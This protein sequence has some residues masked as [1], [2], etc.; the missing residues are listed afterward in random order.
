VSCPDEK[1]PLPRPKGIPD[2][3]PSIGRHVREPVD[4]PSWP[5]GKDH[6]GGRMISP[7]LETVWAVA[8][9]AWILYSRLTF[10]CP[11]FKDPDAARLAFG[12][13]QRLQGVLYSEGAY[14]L[15][16][17]Q[18][19]TYLIFELPARIFRVDIAGLEHF[20]ALA[21]AVLMIGILVLN[22]HLAFMIWGRRVALVSTTVLSISPM[23]WIAGEYPTSLVPA[24]FF[25]MLA[26][27]AMVMS[28]RVRGGRWWLVAS[29]VLS[30]WSILT[31]LDMLFGMLVPLCYSLF[32]DRRGLRRA[33]VLYAIV[34]VILAIFWF[35]VLRSTPAEI[36]SLG[37]HRPDYASSLMLNWWGMGP[38]LFVFAFAGFV[39]RFV[40]DRKPLPFIFFWIVGF[41]TFHTG[42]L[43]SPAPFIS[44]YPVVSWLAAFSII[45]LYSWLVRLVRFNR[46]MRIVFMALFAFGAITTL[47]MS[48]IK[49]GDRWRPH[50]SLRACGRT[51]IAWG[52]T[53]AYKRDDGLFPTGAAWYYMQDFRKG[54]GLQYSWI[55]DGT[56]Q[57]AIDLFHPGSDAFPRDRPALYVGRESQAYLNYFLLA[58]GWEFDE[59]RGPFLNFIVRNEPPEM[60]PGV[61]ID[62]SAAPPRLMQTVY[63][64]DE[65]VPELGFLS[66]PTGINAFVGRD[67]IPVLIGQEGLVGIPTL[68][69][70]SGWH[71]GYSYAGLDLLVPGPQGGSQADGTL[72]CERELIRFFHTDPL[73]RMHVRLD[74]EERSGQPVEFPGGFVTS[75]EGTVATGTANT[76]FLRDV[77]ELSWI[78]TVE[79]ERW[80]A[81][82]IHRQ[83]L[84]PQ[85][86]LFVN[87]KQ[88]EEPMWLGH[89]LP[90]RMLARWDIILIPPDCLESSQ[91]DFRLEAR[92]PGS[93]FDIFWV[94]R[95]YP[96]CQYVSQVARPLGLEFADIACLR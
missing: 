87:E 24:L 54:K 57:A 15:L 4:G 1:P 38:F 23:M 76:L 39:Y 42:H 86:D 30:A 22:A 25:F 7:P 53:I 73:P 80:M 51:R 8:L 78:S 65:P 69:A 20:L 32:V 55:E 52:E 95:D 33:L 84:L 66:G 72:E 60:P 50:A 40:T 81:L 46:P 45:A 62:W 96:D 29:A 67:A 64:E 26:V 82:A 17:R 94:Q 79:P 59:M 13:G 77:D 90:G 41:N 49:E 56:R 36:F 37:P 63:V 9:V 34:A 14:H 28:Y 89:N 3:H 85:Y 12:V 43:Y 18:F 10:I 16:D 47:T 93:I 44:Y 31:R 61:A 11:Y 6:G 70:Y 19:G 91:V 74:P 68:V 88:I 71:V 75:L 27:W 5:A 58:D 83:G 35:G 48:T 2:G 92:I 21:C